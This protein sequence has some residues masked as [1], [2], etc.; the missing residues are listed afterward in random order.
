[1]LLDSIHTSVKQAEPRL[2]NIFT[3]SYTRKHTSKDTLETT[4]REGI[5]CTRSTRRY[6]IRQMLYYNEQ[7]NDTGS[8]LWTG[9][10]LAYLVK[11]PRGEDDLEQVVGYED[12]LELEGLAVLHQLRPQ[13]FDDVD[14]GQ[15]DEERRE[16]RAH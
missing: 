14:I 6:I 8:L 5:L 3:K 15:A 13:Y 2:Y 12:I 10:W 11:E 16:G 1:M 9:S 4:E 7:N